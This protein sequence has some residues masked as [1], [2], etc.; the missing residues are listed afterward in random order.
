MI[1]H[2]RNLRS[3][4]ADK[5]NTHL[6]TYV[7]VT[8]SPTLFPLLHCTSPWLFCNYQLVLLNL[9]SLKLGSIYKVL[10]LKDKRLSEATAY[11]QTEGGPCSC[12]GENAQISLPRGL[13]GLKWEMMPRKFQINFWGAQSSGNISVPRAAITKSPQIGWLK[14]TEICSLPALEARR[15][16]SSC[17]QGYAP[18]ET[19]REI[20]PSLPSPGFWLLVIFGVPWLTV[21]AFQSLPSSSHGILPVSLS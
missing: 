1:T 5:S 8:R 15:L 19:F 9:F 3:D 18:Y 7:V 12:K 4:H 13:A 20:L 11:S 14:T 21:A 16:K 2:L 6:Q 10:D 17:W